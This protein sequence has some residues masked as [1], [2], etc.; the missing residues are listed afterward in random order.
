MKG[1][2]STPSFRCPALLY[3]EEFAAFPAGQ[4]LRIS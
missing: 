2:R 3:Q 4:E 1:Q